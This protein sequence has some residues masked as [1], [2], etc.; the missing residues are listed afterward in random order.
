MSQRQNT[1][2]TITVDSVIAKKKEGLEF[3]SMNNGL[4]QSKGTRVTYIGLRA[5]TLMKD[6]LPGSFSEG[7]YVHPWGN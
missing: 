2:D 3:S 5:L 7:G 1:L 6:F 4:G